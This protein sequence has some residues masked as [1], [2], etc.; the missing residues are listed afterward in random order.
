MSDNGK[1]GWWGGRPVAG[2]IGET[3]PRQRL[4]AEGVVTE[5]STRQWAEVPAL[6]C[7]L[8][9]GTGRVLLAF[10][11]RQDLSGLV[12]G[13]RCRV[14]ATAMPDPHGELLVLWNP[15]YELLAASDAEL[16]VPPE[17]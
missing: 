10:T 16:T 8:D 6:V 1:R 12:V 5:L 13:V 11:G 7:V 14:E 15:R 4:V 9:D 17:W 3:R 2:T